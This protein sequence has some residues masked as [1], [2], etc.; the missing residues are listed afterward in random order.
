MVDLASHSGRSVQPGAVMWHRR[1]DLASRGWGGCWGFLAQV[2]EQAVA[3]EADAP[4]DQWPDEPD[5]AWAR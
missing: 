4:A 3:E 5:R 2:D 1:G